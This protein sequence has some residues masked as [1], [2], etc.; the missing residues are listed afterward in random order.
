MPLSVKSCHDQVEQFLAQSG[1]L[2]HTYWFL[3]SVAA[4][5]AT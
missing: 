2:Q 4:C 1:F 3:P 5:K